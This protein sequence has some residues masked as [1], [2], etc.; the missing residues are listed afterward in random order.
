MSKRKAEP[1]WIVVATTAG[2]TQA[3][4]IAEH[5][6]SLGIPAIVQNESIG[7]V[8]GISIGQLGQARVA[9]LEEYLDRARDVLEK[10]SH[11]PSLKNND[12]SDTN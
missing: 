4:M 8:L 10:R 3:A 11:R 5:L 12:E 2:Y 7:L 6:H 9:V 1:N